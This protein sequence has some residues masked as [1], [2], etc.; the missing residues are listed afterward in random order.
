[1]S[2]EWPPASL[3][4]ED[5]ESSEEIIEF[6]SLPEPGASKVQSKI[7]GKGNEGFSFTSTTISRPAIAESVT[8]DSKRT[9]LSDSS[10]R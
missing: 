9:Y 1:L 4:V 6:D 7:V 10:I 2:T 5:Y 8:C 3:Q